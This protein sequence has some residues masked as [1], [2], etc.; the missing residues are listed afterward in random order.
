MLRLAHTRSRF[1]R[2]IVSGFAAGL[3]VW[4]MGTSAV[5]AVAEPAATGAQLYR[6]A[7]GACHGVTGRGDGRDADLYDPRP[8][9]LHSGFLDRYE[10]DDLV[11]RVRQGT[12]LQIALD[13]PALR[14]RAG[15]TEA[16]AAH[17]Q[18]LPGTDWRRLEGG[19]EIFVDRCEICH[20]PFGRAPVV[21]PCGV[22]RSRDLSAPSFQRQIT[23]RELLVLVRHGREGM[24]AITPRVPESDATA[25]AAF[26]RLLSPGFELYSRYCSA[27]HGDD[28]Q[29]AGSFVDTLG[30]PTVIF[31]RRYFK[32]RDPE[33]VRR[34]IWHMLAEQ[35]PAM[36]H[37]RAALDEAEA[38]A[39]VQ[40]LKDVDD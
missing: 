37:M 17:L 14:A 2:A 23:E 3:V 27:C 12:P 16:I 20:G 13:L 33:E 38:R 21:L 22:Q 30:R 19:Q 31:D 34:G 29:P 15:E 24:P 10:T 7:C 35:K 8:R 4:T 40:Y 28:G 6:E 11:R 9:D 18:R 25:L 5:A 32:R 1:G 39:I 26:V 36:P